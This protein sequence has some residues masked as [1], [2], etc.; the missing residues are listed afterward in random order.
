MKYTFITIQYDF[1]S[2]LLNQLGGGIGGVVNMGMGLLGQAFGNQMQRGQQQALSDQQLAANEKL[3]DYNFA[4]QLKFWQETNYPAQVEQLKEAGLNPALLYAKGGPGGSTGSPTSGM[5]M[6]IAAPSTNQ[7][8][9]MIE[10][11]NAAADIRLKN[12]Q[13]ANIEAQTPQEANLM[14][15]QIASITQGVQNQQATEI[16]T[17]AQTQLQNLQ[18]TMQGATIDDQIAQIKA[19]ATEIEQ[20][21]QQAVRNNYIDANTMNAKI[22]T[23]QGIMLGTFLQ[24]QLTQAQTG[25][26][27]SQ[28]NLNKQQIQE[29]IQ[30]IQQNWQN[31]DI[32]KQNANTNEGH[33]KLQQLIKDLPDSSG[34]LMDAASRVLPF[35]I[36][37]L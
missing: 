21:S 30:R 29:S 20:Q 16:L 32:N 13:A 14:N 26:A 15:A 8:A 6:G 17:K 31:I 11:E 28:T 25:Q 19:T 9:T 12:A 2:D 7:A 36:A 24:N 23:I 22:K 4:N 1:G 37:M 34:K 35:I 10:S 27:N 18:N 33:L 5:G 3:S